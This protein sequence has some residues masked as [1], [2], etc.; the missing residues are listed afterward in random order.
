MQFAALVQER[1]DVVA[2]GLLDANRK[3][4]WAF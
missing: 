3:A 1:R 2:F 4:S